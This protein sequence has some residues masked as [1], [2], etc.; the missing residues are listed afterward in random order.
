MVKRGF[1]AGKSTGMILLDVEK[2]YDSVWQDVVVYKLF[3]SNLQPFLVKI[4]GQSEPEQVEHGAFHHHLLALQNLDP[5]IPGVTTRKIYLLQQWTPIR[6]SPGKICSYCCR[7]RGCSGPLR[8]RHHCLGF[9][10]N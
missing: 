3:R 10:R 5:D 8:N 6:S 7:H 2:A 9:H 1:L 4:F